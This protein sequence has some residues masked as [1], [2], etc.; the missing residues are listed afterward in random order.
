MKR[1]SNK[2]GISPIIATLLLILIAIAAGVVVYAYVIGFVGNSTVNSGATQDQI[3]IDQV[4]LASATAGFP[5][6]AYVRNLGPSIET[7]DVGFYLKSTTINTQLTPA[8]S[9]TAANAAH[10]ITVS[11]VSLAEASSTTLTVTIITSACTATTDEIIIN[12]FG[13]AQQTTTGTCTVSGSSTLTA[14]LTLTGGLQTSTSPIYHEPAHFGTNLY[15]HCY[16]NGRRP[17]IFECEI[18]LEP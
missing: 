6:I 17:S 11:S 13:A 5:S 9:L 14:T 16:R 3:S 15:T 2:K 7:F 1:V 12:G 10:T 4:S 8:V 18:N